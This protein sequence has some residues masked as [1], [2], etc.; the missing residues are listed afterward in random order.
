ML[1]GYGIHTSVFPSAHVAGAFSAAFGMRRALPEHLWV[2]RFLL[3]MAVLIATATVYGRYHYLA[4]AGAGLAMACVA[5]LVARL[6]I[7]SRKDAKA[8]KE[9]SGYVTGEAG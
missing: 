6:E 9:E 8:A 3:V 7:V 5:G 2:W 1:G 4:D